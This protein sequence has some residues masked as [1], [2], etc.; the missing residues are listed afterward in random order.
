VIV[1]AIEVGPLATNAYLVK[2][3]A[4]GSGIVIDPGADGEGLVRRCRNEGLDPVYVINTHGHADHI[5]G[6]AAL[7]RAFPQARLCIGRGDADMLGRPGDNLSLLLGATADSGPADALL[8]EGQ[9]LAAG[10]V[11]MCVLETPGHTPGGICLLCAEEPRQVF[12][13]DLI[14]RGAVGRTDLPGGDTATLLKSIRE[15]ILT[16]PD[17]TVLWPGHGPRTS[18][19][20][21][22]TANPFLVRVDQA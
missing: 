18:V 13:G 1:I 14:F 11:T 21:E 20:E 6:N 9:E 16:L 17:D 22:R 8:S 3:E 10:A 12:C 5:G 4:S 7:R 15:R 2:G 19:G